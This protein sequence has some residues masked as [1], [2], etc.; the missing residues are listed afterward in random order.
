MLS[1]SQVPRS[2]DWSSFLSIPPSHTYQSG[3]IWMR[4]LLWEGGGRREG[5][6][7]ADW[8]RKQ[9][10]HVWK[11]NRKWIRRWCY[12]ENGGFK[13]AIEVRLKIQ[14]HKVS[15]SPHAAG[16]LVSLVWETM[17]G[18]PQNIHGFMVIVNFIVLLGTGQCV[19]WTEWESRPFKKINF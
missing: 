19:K 3:L 1:V 13:E 5:G 7:D 11:I 8:C 2:L 14:Q 10:S 15:I 16:W 17:N 18:V 12:T 6:Q 9:K 4:C